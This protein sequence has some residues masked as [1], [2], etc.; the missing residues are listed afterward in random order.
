[1]KQM[2]KLLAVILVIASVF[3]ICGCQE[4]TAEPTET[5]GK[6]NTSFDPENPY[7]LLATDIQNGC[8][9][10]IN[11]DAEDPMDPDSYY[12]YWTAD[13]AL[14]WKNAGKLSR[15]NLSDARLR[16][17]ELHQS[18]VVLLTSASGWVGIAEYPSGKCLWETTDTGKGPHAV[19]MLPDGD[20]VVA[21]SGGTRWETEGCVM[22]YDTT[23]GKSYTVTCEVMLQSAHGLLWD[24]EYNVLWATGYWNL[25]AYDITADGNGKPVLTERTDK[26]GALLVSGNGHDLMPDYSDPNLLWIT[27]DKAVQKYD[28]T[29]DKVLSGYTY[30]D[31]IAG[32]YR[33]KG[34]TSFAD[35]A[36]AYVQCGDTSNDWMDT[37][38]ILWP[39]DLEGKDAVEVE[40]KAQDGA[41]WNKVRNF[42]PDYQ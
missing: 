9:A 23:D 10:V 17:S 4:Q 2:L 30:S 35:G 27:C 7:L 26:L 38:Q 6:E 24:P 1:M 22:Y 20:L 37:F 25:V 3:L 13:P 5:Q 32:K 42:D 14:G 8:V 15:G 28:K 12:W 19:E 31:M 18:Y 33:V 29:A 21:C 11:L 41:Y 16:W 36:V 39:L 40:Y 34:V